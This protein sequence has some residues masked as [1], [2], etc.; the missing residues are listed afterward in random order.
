M[1]YDS[2]GLINVITIVIVGIIRVVAPGIVAAVAAIIALI[3]FSA[4]L[5]ECALRLIVAAAIIGA[6]REKF[7]VFSHFCLQSRCLRRGGLRLGIIL[8]LTKSRVSICVK[9][10]LRLI[11]AL[12]FF[13]RGFLRGCSFEYPL[14]LFKS[15]R[16]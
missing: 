9:D 5:I 3:G 12:V 8:I 13:R 6:R 4:E 1:N 11:E 14:S 10:L 2:I 15:R 16:I 7:G